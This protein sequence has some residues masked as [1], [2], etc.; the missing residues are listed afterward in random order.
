LV[1]WRVTDDADA[2]KIETEMISQF[3]AHYGAR[4]FANMRN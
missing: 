2:P 1:G 3:R 4:P